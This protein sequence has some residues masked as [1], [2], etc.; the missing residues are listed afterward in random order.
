MGGQYGV[1]ELGKIVSGC[2]KAL[3]S[4]SKFIHGGGI[5]ALWPILGAVESLKAV[6]FQAAGKEIGE[7]DAVDRL[8]VEDIFKANIDLVDKA[9]EAKLLASVDY[10][11]KG[12][13]LVGKGLALVG[14]GKALVL[15]V[16]SFLG[17]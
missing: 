16:K 2:V 4:I 12:V 10:L 14:E 15:E 8:A 6:D 5:F 17:V 1:V 13:A 11:E 7:L 9:V 3:N